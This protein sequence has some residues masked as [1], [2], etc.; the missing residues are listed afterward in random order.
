MSSASSLHLVGITCVGNEADIVEAFVRHNAA[1]L[2]HLFIFEHNT[3]DGTREILDQLVAEGLPITVEHSTEPKFEHLIF[4]NHLF[5][6]ALAT[7][8][9]DWVFPLDC[10][11]FLVVPTREDLDAALT[12]AGEAHVRLKWINYVARP[13]DDGTEPHPL[14]RIRHCYDYPVPS[15]DDN[16]WV[17]KVAINVRFLGDYYLD[18]YEICEGNHFLTL[19]GQ[20]RPIAAPML[21]LDR[22]S[23]AHFPARSANQLGIKT[24][25]AM[26][27]RLGSSSRSAHY[28][29]LWHEVTTGGIGFETLAHSTRNFLDTGRHTP[30]ALKDTPTKF[31]PL[32][33]SGPL[34]YGGSQLPAVSVILKWIERNMLS[35]EQ[36]ATMFR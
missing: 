12:E 16:P 28:A 35:E 11:E 2:D 26:L 4:N 9:T 19:Q 13:D 8:G 15:V 32:P 22:V 36:R 14:R 29:D 34:T 20:Q 27:S 17:W 33:V 6:V 10:D 24:A 5:R 21:P 30:E 3:L 25:M 1:L 18:R 7:P 23:L 31:A